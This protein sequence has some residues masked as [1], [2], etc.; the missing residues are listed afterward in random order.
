MAVAGV[1][2]VDDM[3]LMHID[4]PQFQPH[5]K[6]HQEMTRSIHNWGRLLI[7]TG[8]ALKPEKCSYT[9]INYKVRPNSSWKYANFSTQPECSMTVPSS[10]GTLCDIKHL[11]VTKAQKTL[12]IYMQPDG[13][14]KAHLDYMRRQAQSWVDCLKIGQTPCQITWLGITLQLWPKV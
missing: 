12:G 14:Y 4:T 1:L 13:D 7:A 9:L 5:T 6:V 10:N 3:D 2:F 11:L 8:C